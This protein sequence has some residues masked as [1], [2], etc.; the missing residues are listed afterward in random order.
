MAAVDPP[1]G[2]WLQH[3]NREAPELVAFA[4]DLER[5]E[6]ERPG[7]LMAPVNASVT[8]N[9]LYQRARAAG[10]VIL[11]PHGHLLDRKHTKRASD[12]FPWLTQT[13]RPD[14]QTAW[15][16]WMRQGLRHQLDRSGVAAPTVVV[17]PSPIVTAAAG[18]DELY[19]VLDAAQAVQAEIAEPCW[20]G[21]NIDR[22]YLR[23]PTHVT[24]LTNT[25]VNIA[26]AGVVVR[27]FH[28]ELPPVSD[29][30]Y[31]AGLRELVQALATNGTRVLLPNAGWLGW[32]A[33][34]WGAWGFSGGMAAG[35]WGDR[36]PGPMTSPDEPSRPIFEPQLLRSVRWRVHESLVGTPGYQQCDCPECIAMTGTHDLALAKRHQ[37]RHAHRAAMTLA[38]ATPRLRAGAVAARLDQAIAFRDR[39]PR[40]VRDRADAGFLDRWR[41][42]V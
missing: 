34:A 9:A 27:A 42:V 4:D 24:R 29:R 3:A 17:T 19:A 20:L 41:D 35:S 31:L 23:D 32:L 5:T 13:P 33:M 6:G 40:V 36:E 25:L 7:V 39:L 21:V 16:N 22:T 15:E 11:D 28:N 26:P 2:F 18:Q 14:D 30:A 10:P 37:L 8:V 38:Q 12:H 1:P